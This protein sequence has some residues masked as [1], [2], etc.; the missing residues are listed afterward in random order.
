LGGAITTLRQNSVTE[1]VFESNTGLGFVANGYPTQV[2]LLLNATPPVPEPAPFSLV[3][4]GLGALG[5]GQLLRRAWR[6]ARII[7]LD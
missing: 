4:A 5:V 7:P 6:P 3:A 2:E 1:A